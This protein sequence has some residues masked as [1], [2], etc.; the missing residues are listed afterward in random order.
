[1]EDSCIQK[2]QEQPCKTA[3]LADLEVTE[4]QDDIVGSPM[5]PKG[6]H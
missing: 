3:T 1:M 5:G 4:S 6:D 2:D